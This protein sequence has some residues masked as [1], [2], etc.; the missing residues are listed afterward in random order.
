MSVEEE[1][2][3][4]TQINEIRDRIKRGDTIGQKGSTASHHNEEYKSSINSDT[5]IQEL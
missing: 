2:Q 3:L 1:E 5:G 4:I